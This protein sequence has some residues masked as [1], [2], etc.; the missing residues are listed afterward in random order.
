MAA[1]DEVLLVADD[2]VVALARAGK[3]EGDDLV[4]T[5]RAPGVRRPGAG[6]RADADRRR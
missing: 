4:L 6:R 2:R 1:D 3:A 5:Y